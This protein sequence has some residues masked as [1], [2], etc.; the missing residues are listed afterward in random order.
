MPI[1]AKDFFSLPI[2]K[3]SSHHGVSHH[4]P[5]AQLVEHQTFVREIAGSNPG[6]TNTQGL[7]KTEE[8]VL[9]L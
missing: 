5:M 8:K 6:Q 1:L 9:P 7:K 2:L 3:N 4:G